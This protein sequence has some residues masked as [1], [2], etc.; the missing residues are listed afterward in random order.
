M[1][2]TP[3]QHAQFERDDHIPPF[4]ELAAELG[5]AREAAGA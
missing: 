4:A 1:K 3:E 2:L 5:R